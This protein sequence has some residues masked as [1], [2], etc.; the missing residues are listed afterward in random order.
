MVVGLLMV[1]GLLVCYFTESGI[2]QYAGQKTLIDVFG[3]NF[4]LLEQ[5]IKK[6]TFLDIK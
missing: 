1:K 4:L 6:S 5:Y 2:N 3:S